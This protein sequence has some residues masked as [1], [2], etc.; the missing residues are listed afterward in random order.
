MPAESSRSHATVEQ[1]RTAIDGDRTH[2]KVRGEDPAAA[3]LGADE[4]AAGTPP[5]AAARDRAAHRALPPDDAMPAAIT[6]QFNWPHWI[7]VTIGAAFIVLV[8]FW[9]A[10]G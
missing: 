9:L 10:V 4:E 1:V 6:P 7:A 8:V 3:P 5:P 2:D